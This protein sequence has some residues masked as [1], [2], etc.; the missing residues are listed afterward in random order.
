MWASCR[1]MTFRCQARAVHAVETLPSPR[2]HLRASV[3]DDSRRPERPA[4]P[5]RSFLAFA[6]PPWRRLRSW[7]G[8]PPAAGCRGG[9]LVHR[10]GVRAGSGS[11]A[12]GGRCRAEP[13]RAARVGRA[14][15]WLGVA[16][17]P[18]PAGAPRGG[19]WG[20]GEPG[21]AEP[22]SP[23]AWGR[24][25]RWGRCRPAG[26]TAVLRRGSATTEYEPARRDARAHHPPTSA[27]AP[28]APPPR[29]G[30][31]APGELTGAE[32][33]EGRGR[34]VRR[35]RRERRRKQRTTGRGPCGGR[36]SERLGAGR[37]L[38]AAQG[39]AQ[40]LGRRLTDVTPH[41]VWGVDVAR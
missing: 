28:R 21:L 15:A 12:G 25:A 20:A 16:S 5:F 11:D 29:G 34:G 33:S 38:H 8:R 40:A 41:L 32:T 7:R 14:R 9:W 18:A 19:R 1:P 4:T 26:A 6:P 36:G 13:G 24:C 23:A 39:A 17:G 37:S 10:G 35:E 30:R 27:A 3:P 22:G 31:A 2:L